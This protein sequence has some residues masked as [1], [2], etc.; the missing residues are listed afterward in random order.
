MRLF[1]R[2]LTD[3]PRLGWRLAIGF[4]I[5]SLGLE[6][7]GGEAFR[8][9]RGLMLLSAVALLICVGTSIVERNSWQPGPFIGWAHVAD[10]LGRFVGPALLLSELGA[11]FSWESPG[12]WDELWKTA[13]AGVL[14]GY[15]LVLAWLIWRG[16]RVSVVISSAFGQATGVFITIALWWIVAKLIRFFTG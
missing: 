14:E 2:K 3:G 9:V 1:P 15:V 16:S 6:W 13:V 5:L 8:P 7:F 12:F 4:L 11:A 10:N